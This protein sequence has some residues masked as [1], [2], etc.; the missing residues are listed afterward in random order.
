MHQLLQRIDALEQCSR[1]HQRRIG[2]L[3]SD[4]R[5]QQRQIDELESRIGALEG[6]TKKRNITVANGLVLQR[7]RTITVDLSFLDNNILFLFAS[8]LTT[9]DLAN[10]G[11]TCGRFEMIHD[12]Q[13][14][15]LA[16]EAAGQIFG[17][18]ATG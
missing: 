2:E 11:R 16:N 3:E 18:T 17:S 8:Y 9:T 10:L 15:L 5:N 13:R 14:R 1:D 12:G 4:K 7:I 6:E